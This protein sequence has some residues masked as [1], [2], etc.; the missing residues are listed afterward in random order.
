MQ[1]RARIVAQHAAGVECAHRGEVRREE[2]RRLGAKVG[3]EQAADAVAP[4]AGAL[5]FVG[6]EIV[7]A[8]AGMEVDHPEWR[9]LV[10]QM[11]ENAGEDR[12]L[13]D[14]GK[15]PGVKGVAI[16]HGAPG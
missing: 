12:V 9:R 10:A 1:R 11:H 7:E 4:F 5:R 16:V 8:G 15:I 14:V 6:R 2:R 13:E 3:R